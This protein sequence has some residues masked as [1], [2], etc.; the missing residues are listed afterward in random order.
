[1]SMVDIVKGFLT[2]WKRTSPRSQQTVA[3]RRNM[4]RPIG[5]QQCPGKNMVDAQP[6][7]GWPP[8]YL[9]YINSLDHSLHCPGIIISTTLPSQHTIRTQVIS[10]PLMQRP[11]NTQTQQHKKPA[12]IFQAN[13][14]KKTKPTNKPAFDIH[15]QT[16]HPI[17]PLTPIHPRTSQP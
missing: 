3:S 15:L 2:E 8:T 14:Q 4:T 6:P 17:P 1:M 12:P 16:S 9:D 10:Y 7:Y 11:T 5:W 13:R